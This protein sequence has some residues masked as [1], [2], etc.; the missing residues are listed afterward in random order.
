MTMG[1][2]AERFSRSLGLSRPEGKTTPF[3][4]AAEEEAE[5]GRPWPR[6]GS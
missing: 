6:D 3:A 1:L 5:S 2:L 4:A